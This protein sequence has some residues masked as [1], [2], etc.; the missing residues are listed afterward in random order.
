MIKLIINFVSI[1]KRKIRY[2]KTSYA[3]NGVDLIIEYIFKKEKK[4][5]YLDIGSQ[6]PISNNNTYL[7]YKKGWNGINIDLDKKNIDLFK[8][9]RP[10]DIN[11]NY[12]ISD[13]EG[14]TDLFFY[15]ESS[16][17]N[18]LNKQVS[19]YQKAAVKEIKKVKTF[20]LNYILNKLNFDKRIDYMNLDVEGFELKVLN[21]FDI[22]KYKP[23]VISVEYLDLK[24]K[25]LEFKNN[26]IENLLDSE[27][28]KYFK[29]N[30]YNFVN[31]LHG[32]LIFIHKDFR[33]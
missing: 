9:A 32:D 4:G 20:T 2:K 25:K 23:K 29:T 21:G 8:I 10:K 17:I 27:L 18:T 22:Q 6:H 28:Y 26:N 24:M 3:F 30:D 14:V 13:T 1:L 19:S 31:W 16:P 15:H 12:A 33:D 11:L 7:L 5:I